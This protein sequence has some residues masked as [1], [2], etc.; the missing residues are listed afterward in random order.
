MLPPRRG[1][2]VKRRVQPG[3][4]RKGP[5]PSAD[6][7]VVRARAAAHA[8]IER[9]RTADEGRREPGDPTPES[10]FRLLFEGNPIPMLVH[11]LDRQSI[12]A[13]NDAAVAHYG[14]PRE[15]F[16]GMTLYD[17]HDPADHAGLP[18]IAAEFPGGQP[19]RT[20]RHRKADGSVI[21][22]AMYSATLTYQHRRSA[23]IAAIDITERKRAEARVAFMAEHDVLT[24]LPNRVL[25]RSHLA[26]LLGRGRRGSRHLAVLCLNLDNFKTVN[27]TLGHPVG[28]LLLQTIA[29]RL[30]ASLREHDVAAR[31]GGDEFAILQP[32]IEQPE[33][34]GSL[35]QRLIAV[36]AE[37]CLIDGHQVVVGASIGIALAPGDGED[38]DRL[39]KNADMALDRAKAD[40]GAG[41]RV[42]EPGMDARLQ[43]RRRLEVDLRA[44]LAAGA[45]EVHYQP[46]V[47]LRGGTVAG[48]EA[49]LRWPHAERGMIPPGEFIP[50]A[51]ET[52]LIA[53]LGALVLRRACQ[54]AAAWPADI[55]VA[56]NLSPL[57]FRTGNLL[58]LVMDTLRATGLKARRLELEI[59][60]G[61]LLDHNELVLATLHALR[62]LGV[63]IAMDDFGTGY[64]SLS[65]LRSF[66][67][68]KIKIDRSFIRDMGSS[69]GA[70]A[71]VRA[72]VSLGTSL[73]ITI[74]AEG[75]E[76]ESDLACLRAEGCSQA[77][78]FLFSQARPQAEIL[79][80]LERQARAR[81]A[82]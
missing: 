57:Q 31:L 17:I 14:W 24:S 20:W 9:A 79:R 74:T 40:G 44:G 68:D 76:T 56:V 29:Q 81:S 67:F 69:A 77:Q 10:S 72:I 54:D 16:I 26:K 66:P 15:T 59:T 34:A 55:T 51:E 61:L 46:L 28:D 73:G 27:D 50:V 49:L 5:R 30:R 38:A 53:P 70:Q 4:K 21:D 3:P 39:M 8:A 52:G 45:F 58:G 71:I 35:A 22:V 32:G 62:A 18:G 25:L 1:S 19:G 6:A 78:G 65:Y 2:P 13:V 64:S 60:E 36:I 7:A 37:P 48:F 82:A 11:D 41:F 33:E 23:L 75:V 12:V 63:R 43:A 47:D 42:F 80:V